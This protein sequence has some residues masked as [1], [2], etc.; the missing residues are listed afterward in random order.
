[1]KQKRKASE[2]NENR[3]S[4]FIPSTRNWEGEQKYKKN[5]ERK[6]RKARTHDPTKV[7]YNEG[8]FHMVARITTRLISM[9]MLLRLKC[10]ARINK[11]LLR[12]MIARGRKLQPILMLDISL[13]KSVSQ[14]QRALANAKL[15]E[16][17]PRFNV[18]II[19]AGVG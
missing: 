15:C 14:W 4:D 7:F 13:G 2:V 11:K 10:R 19:W 5:R 9:R 1:M 3:E 16:F 6:K 8:T 12:Y 18:P 17:G